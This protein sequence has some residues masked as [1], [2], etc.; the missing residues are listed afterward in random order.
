MGSAIL[1]V[2]FG[3]FAVGLMLYEYHYRQT[4]GLQA[5][6]NG[7]ARQPSP[8]VTPAGQRSRGALEVTMQYDAPCPL[9]GGTPVEILQMVDGKAWICPHC[10]HQET[11]GA[12]DIDAYVERL[13]HHDP[14]TVAAWRE[15]LGLKSRS[16]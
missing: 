16:S 7:T 1:A 12:A 5:A 15:A 14:E 13:G 2:V 11:E 10:G 6:E 9:C 3:A 4:H 8:G